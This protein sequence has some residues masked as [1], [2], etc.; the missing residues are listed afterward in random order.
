MF[1]PSIHQCALLPSC[2]RQKCSHFTYLSFKFALDHKLKLV[3]ILPMLHMHVKRN[4][5]PDS[6]FK[7][8]VECFIQ[9]TFLKL[10]H[11]NHNHPLRQSVLLKATVKYLVCQVRSKYLVA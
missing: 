6:D 5:Q 11:H 2:K 10:K 1:W 3:Q 4:G 9:M 7:Q 8:C